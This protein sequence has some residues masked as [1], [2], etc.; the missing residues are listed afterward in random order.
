[1]ENLS[2]PVTL[3]KLPDIDDVT[4]VVEKDQECL[5]EIRNVLLKYDCLNRFGISLLHDHFPMADDEILVEECDTEKRLLISRPMK[6]SE[7]SD[8]E[9]IETN[10][11]LDTGE[12]LSNC[13]RRCRKISGL[14]SI[15][16]R[17]IE[18]PEY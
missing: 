14:H 2:N 12:P 3:S 7:I 11:R 9:V 15:S 6:R 13:I 4:P 18:F 17:H 16:H 1:M 8:E 5:K 10:W